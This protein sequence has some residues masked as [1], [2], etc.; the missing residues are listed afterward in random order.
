MEFRE[1]KVYLSPHEKKSARWPSPITLTSESLAGLGEDIQHT[2]DDINEMMGGWD[3]ITHDENIELT[4]LRDR[5]NCRMGMYRSI[6]RYAFL[7]LPDIFSDQLEDLTPESF[8]E[9]T[10]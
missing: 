6:A 4:I 7:H 10:K 1:N 8:L 2:V 9:L 5:L 3:V